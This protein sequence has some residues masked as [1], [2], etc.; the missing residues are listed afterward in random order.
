MKNQTL[1]HLSGVTA[2]ELL[3]EMDSVRRRVSNYIDDRRSQ[4]VEA[5]RGKINGHPVKKTSGR[6]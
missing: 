2:A 6:S 5:A 4:L 3:A 1:K